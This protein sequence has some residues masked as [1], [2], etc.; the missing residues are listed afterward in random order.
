MILAVGSSC[1]VFFAIYLEDL[2]YTGID[3]GIF[4]YPA[5]EFKCEPE[6]V[7]KYFEKFIGSDRI[8]DC[9]ATYL[10]PLNIPN[11]NA[12]IML[13]VY[14]SENEI[15][16]FA[17]AMNNDFECAIFWIPVQ[18]NLDLREYLPRKL[19]MKTLMFGKDLLIIY[20]I[21]GI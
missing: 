2:T 17:I 21:S 14:L 18:E 3:S 19:Y 10:C 16:D 6:L 12:G 15:P 8:R 20:L 9:Q 4:N 1:K 13:G 11:N 7:N 5:E